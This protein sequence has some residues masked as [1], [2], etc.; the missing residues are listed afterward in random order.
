VSHG[1]GCLGIIRQNPFSQR[2][3]L[4]VGIMVYKKDKAHK[5]TL[6]V[7]LILLFILLGI[8]LLTQKA[9]HCMEIK[10]CLNFKYLWQL[11]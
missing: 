1:Y 9:Y 4:L 6:V 10:K 11:G 5:I 3:S 2:I 8:G 7:A